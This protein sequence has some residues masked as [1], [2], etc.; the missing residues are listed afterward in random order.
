MRNL[1]PTIIENGIS[2]ILVGDYYIPEI[3]MEESKLF[4]HW[5][6]M[7]LAYLK[8]SRPIFYSNLIL[9][10]KLSLY[11]HTLDTQASARLNL[12]IEQMQFSEGVN[13]ALKQRDQLEWVRRMNSIRNRAEEIVKSEMIYCLD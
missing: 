11:L 12:V 6:R 5:G 2:Y 9:S 13:E 10:G 4:G 1:Q 3:K 8:E 7:H